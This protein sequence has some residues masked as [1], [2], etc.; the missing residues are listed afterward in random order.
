MKTLADLK[1]YTMEIEDIDLWIAV[2]FIGAAMHSPGWG[3]FRWL[4]NKGV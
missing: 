4:L 2:R 1:K 3:F